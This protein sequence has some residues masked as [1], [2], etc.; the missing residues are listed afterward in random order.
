MCGRFV[1]FSAYP[2]LARKVG[3]F[4][5]AELPPRY[6][7]PPGTWITAIRRTAHDEPPIQ[8]DLWWGYKPAWAKGKA[9]QP[10]NARVE[11][12]A[13]SGYFKNAFQKRRCII[14]ADGWFEWLKTTTPKTPHY[15]T[16]TDREP[17]AFA[18]IC[19][20]RDDGSLGCVI[21][22]EPARGS[23][24]DVHDRMPLILDDDSLEPWLDPDL[25]ERETIRNVVKHIDADLIEHWAVSIAVNKPGNGED[26]E[27]INPA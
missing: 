9:S 16:R 23:A 15:L 2:K 1:L 13:T 19:T 24:Q 7:I 27:L 11:T 4:S 17:I 5:A 22:T 26:A 8:A 3:V 10:I 12:V 18:G 14:P 25:T 20:E 6:N 21:I